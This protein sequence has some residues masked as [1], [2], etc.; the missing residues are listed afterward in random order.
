MATDDAS[1]DVKA[2]RATPLTTVAA[3]GQVVTILVT[4]SLWN[5]RSTPPNLPLLSALRPLPFA[6]PLLLLAAVAVVKPRVAAPLFGAVSVTSVLADQTRLQPEVISLALLMIAPLYGDYGRSIARWHLTTMWVWAGV[7]KALSLGWSTGG[8]RFIADSL[9]LPGLRVGVA[10]ALP[11]F[12]VGVGVASVARR[13]WPAVRWAGLA[14]HLGIFVTLSPPFANWN[15]SVWAWNLALAGAALLVFSPRHDSVVPR[16]AW[17][18]P[19]AAMVVYPALFYVGAVDAYL[20]HNL[21]SSNTATAFVCS[22]SGCNGRIFDTWSALNV[23]LPPEP[24]LFRQLFDEVCVPDTTLVV[25]GPATRLT[26]PP[27]TQHHPC[28]RVDLSTA[29]PAPTTTS[30][31]TST[32]I[33]TTSS[34]AT[35]TTTTAPRAA[36]SLA[37]KVIVLDPGHNEGNSHHTAEINHT[38]DVGNGSKA[39]DTTGT[40]TNDGYSEASY[41]TDIAS[42]VAALLRDDGAT[43]V[44]TRDAST[45]WGPCID[46]R[47]AIGN[48]AH[49]DAAI[50]IHGDGGPSTGR[51]FHV[52][53]PLLVAGHNDGIIEPSQRLALLVRDAFRAATGLPFSTYL[54]HDGIDARSDLGGLNLSTVPKVFI[55]TANMR[56]AADAALLEDP[57]FRQKIAVGIANGLIDFVTAT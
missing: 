17:R 35:T 50:S 29:G 26:D 48:N 52:I 30:T 12:E 31:T 28:P 14:L 54:G 6:L 9:H 42:R 43:V 18:I 36:P 40:A 39:C 27:S 13:A 34:T 41:T 3:A 4:W 57:A 19:I 10:I 2:G 15:S 51:G 45:P 5:D 21:Y 53:E 47:A 56:N 33:T 16:G 37:G 23:P 20:S 7:H 32:S 46:E 11:L 44:L 8:A 1:A 49:A 22:A 55:E 25:V 38:V 24:R